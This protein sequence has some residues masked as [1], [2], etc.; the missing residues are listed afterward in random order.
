MWLDTQGLSHTPP[1]GLPH[2]FP[3]HRGHPGLPLRQK[4]EVPGEGPKVP[5]PRAGPTSPPP[6]SAGTNQSLPHPGPAPS[7]TA[8]KVIQRQFRH[9]YF[10]KN[11]GSARHTQQIDAKGIPICLEKN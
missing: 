6:T 9:G 4:G 7:A 1:R 11:R 8:N 3:R 2:R 10:W 5:G